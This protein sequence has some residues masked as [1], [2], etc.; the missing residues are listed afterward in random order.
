MDPFK[1]A[2]KNA[3]IWRGENTIIWYNEKLDGSFTVL[4]LYDFGDKKRRIYLEV[5]DQ[6]QKVEFKNDEL[7]KEHYDALL[8]EIF[9]VEKLLNESKQISGSLPF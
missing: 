9:V 2:R 8:Q 4:T 5:N 7:N 1:E 6:N 3:H